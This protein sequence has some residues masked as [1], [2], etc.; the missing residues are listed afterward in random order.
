MKYC[1]HSTLALLFV[2]T[3]VSCPDSVGAQTSVGYTN[4]RETSNLLEYRLPDWSYRIWDASFDLSGSGRDLNDGDTDRINNSNGGNLVTHYQQ[5]WDSEQRRKNWWGD[6]SG[7]YRRAHSGTDSGEAISKQLNGSYNLGGGWREYLGQSRFNVSASGSSRRSYAENR[8]TR[9]NEDIWTESSD[10]NRYATHH[11]GGGLG[12]GRTRNV[13]PLLRAQRLSERLAS[14][15]RSPLTRQQIQ[16][17][18]GVLATEQGYREVFDRSD[19][20]F[21]QDVLAPMLDD[22]HPLDPYEIF[23]LADV[24][25]ED[26]GDRQEG[27]L[28]QA[29]YTYLDATANPGAESRNRRQRSPR[30]SLS[31]FHNFSLTQQL[32][33]YGILSYT[34]DNDAAAS[35]EF[36]SSSAGVGHLWNLADRYR[37]DTTLAYSGSNR[38]NGPANRGRVS[39]SSSLNVFIEDQASLVFQAK[40]NYQ[41]DHFESY[42]RY[43]WAWDYRLGLTYHL[44]RAIF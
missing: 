6:L 31:W 42:K 5:N 39:I 21:W 36:A 26:L 16:T 15:G 24:L 12:W 1:F 43:G 9:R 40:A 28:V 7:S 18:A 25:N 34:W 35:S 4:P 44:D 13:V 10:I 20:H 23:Y 37:L 11:L 3:A 32:N 19:R 38:P 27:V 22:S 30:L 8:L 17:I 41:W 29:T 14:L 2:L 33:L